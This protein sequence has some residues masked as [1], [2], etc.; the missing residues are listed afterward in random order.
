[1][2]VITGKVYFLEAFWSEN[3]YVYPGHVIFDNIP[4]GGDCWVEV[5]S[6]WS[7]CA[8]CG[9]VVFEG[10]HA[11]Q[12]AV[13]FKRWI[14]P[15]K[16]EQRPQ[17]HPMCDPDTDIYYADVDWATGTFKLNV[18]YNVCG[19]HMVNATVYHTAHHTL[20]GARCGCT[21]TTTPKSCSSIGYDDNGWWGKW[22]INDP[23]I[24]AVVACSQA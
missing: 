10:D 19:T 21:P 17:L 14:S 2:P 7:N 5:T 9:E 3:G 1:M 12:V 24:P 23:N 16:G 13:S 20:S 8:V 6:L 22:N 15:L 4:V 18:P 11:G